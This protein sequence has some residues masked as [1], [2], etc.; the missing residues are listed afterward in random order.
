[1]H[2]GALCLIHPDRFHEG[3]ERRP[4]N[5][6]TITHDDRPGDLGDPISRSS[7]AVIARPLR[8]RSQPS[9]SCEEAATRLDERSRSGSAETYREQHQGHAA[10]NAARAV[11]YFW[12]NHDHSERDNAPH[13]SGEFVKV[14]CFG[15][16]AVIEADDAAAVADAFVAHGRQSHTWAYPEEAI[17]NY[18]GTTARRP[19][20]SPGR[21]NECLRS[22]TSRC[23]R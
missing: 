12:Q 5:T 17:R 4:R 7:G 6:V 21:Q 18:A 13:E 15:C 8:E 23:N 1:M 3:I 10:E 9:T 2:A 16:D 20:D 22:A 11:P 19:S 14:K